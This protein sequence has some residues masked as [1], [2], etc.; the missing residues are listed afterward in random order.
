MAPSFQLAIM[1]LMQTLG[2]YSHS[3]ATFVLVHGAWHGPWCWERLIPELDARGHRSIAVDL[4]AEDPTATFENYADIVSA[5]IDAETDEEPVLVGHSLGGLTIPLAAARRSVRRLMFVCALLP[6]PGKSLVE[7]LASEPEMVLPDYVKGLSEPDA[8]N[9]TRWI[10]FEIARDSLYPDCDPADARAAFDRLRP[11]GRAGYAEPCPLTALP[12]VPTTYVCCT[13][14]ALVN[15]AWGRA[16]PRERL[17]VDP[18]LLPGGHFPLL[19]RPADVAD[20]L[21]RL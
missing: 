9:R 8:Q 12:D 3:V 13:E 18:V 19:S 4:P 7:Q 21:N 11:Q 6:V 20:I 2:D 5:T 17:G 1:V 14:D 10:D 15:P 16:A